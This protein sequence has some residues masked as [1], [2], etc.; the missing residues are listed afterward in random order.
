MLDTTPA[1]YELTNTKTGYTFKMFTLEDI[2]A[3][4]LVTLA[5]AA[6]A[7]RDNGLLTDRQGREYRC[8][9]ISPGRE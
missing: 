5:D 9:V 7:F 1:W 4:F 6:A 8:R 3:N 2:K